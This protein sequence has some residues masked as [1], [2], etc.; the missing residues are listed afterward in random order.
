LGNGVAL[1][2][3]VMIISAIA[4]FLA[5]YFHE[6]L[7]TWEVPAIFASLVVALLPGMW[8]LR[9][10][11]R[12]WLAGILAGLPLAF[13]TSLSLLHGWKAEVAIA[14]NT[15]LGGIFI[16]LLIVLT[17]LGA[18]SV[19]ILIRSRRLMANAFREIGN[20]RRMLPP[21][22]DDGERFTVFQN[23]WTWLQSCL[24]LAVEFA[25]VGVALR[26]VSVNGYVR[27][28]AFAFMGILL[29]RILAFSKWLLAR[30]ATLV[31][32]PDGISDRVTGIGLIDWR[33]ILD[34]GTYAPPSRT[35]TPRYL[36]IVVA[37]A[38]AVRAR[39]PYLTRM[40]KSF[41][42]PWSLSF[43]IPSILISQDLLDTPVDELAGRIRQYVET[44]APEGWF[45]KNNDNDNA[46]EDDIS[47]VLP[48][49]DAG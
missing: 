30:Q 45:G 11:R 24:I 3:T 41:I 20:E 29:L 1:Y 33:E 15:V 43:V 2:G 12:G 22:R 31:V 16:G 48:D 4:S 25:V 13:G 27:T 28:G 42:L 46:D 39:R 37:D 38:R 21:F 47:P 26:F 17:I 7:R 40:L 36:K 19:V 34:V 10:R 49:S 18:R 6:S 23:R 35:L 5:I 9:V 8:Y 32:G 44:H 14:L